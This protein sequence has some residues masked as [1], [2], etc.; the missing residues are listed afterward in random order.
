LPNAARTAV[1]AAPTVAEQIAQA[2]QRYGVAHIFGQSIPSALLLAAERLGI[3]QVMYRTENAGGAMA[4][5]YARTSHQVGVVAAQNGPAATLLVAPLA[6]AAK[7]SIPVLALVQ[8]VPRVNRGRNAFQE[9]DHEAL[10]TGVAKWIGRLD[11]PARIEADLTSAFR[12]ATTGRPG[13]V[14]LLVD[15]DVLEAP[16]LAQ[17]SRSHG[18]GRYP[19]DRPRPERAAL[20]AAAELLTDARRP[21]V[22]AGGGVHLSDATE[23]LAALQDLASLPVA[24]TTMGKG[25]VDETHPLSVGVVGSFMGANSF[26]ASQ[27]SMVTDADV[28]L[29]VGTRTNENGTDG[30]R[31]YPD[32]ATYVHLDLAPEEV[33][34]NYESVRLVGDARSGLEELVEALGRRDLSRRTEARGEVV[35]QIAQG[36]LHDRLEAAAVTASEQA[37]IRPE[38][39]MAEL[40]HLLDPDDI[41][42][43]DAS[44]STIWAAAYLRSRRAGQRFITPRG[45]AGLGWGLPMALGAKAAEPER[46]VVCLVGDGAFAHTWQELETAV[47]EALPLT[48]I[49]LNN[50]VLGFQQHAELHTWGAHTSAVEFRDVD[51]V[52]IARACGAIGLVVDDPDDLAPVLAEALA[53]EVATVVEVIIDP[54][55]HPPITAWDDSPGLAEWR[56]AAG[57]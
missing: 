36:H 31:L 53:G 37:P 26:T 44:Y 13:P 54:Q 25:A 24:T 18:L 27:R 33:G 17:V 32:E 23:A 2:L 47:R 10:F 35:A 56:T 49:L 4:D 20:E 52:A 50:G 5:G 21:L 38:R 46:T 19:L 48:I 28:I 39:V 15:R 29:L 8:E 40:D 11:E 3:R 51:H 16:A 41:V 12:Q 45:L 42:V 6:E 7:A 14:V 22:I 57:E 1:Q 34:R 9:L 55:A 30:W 43:T